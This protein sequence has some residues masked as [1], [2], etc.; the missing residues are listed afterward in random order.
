M[1]PDFCFG[2]PGRF[3]IAGKVGKVAAFG[4]LFLWEMD[5]GEMKILRINEILMIQM[6]LF[7]DYMYREQKRARPRD[8]VHQNPLSAQKF[9]A[10]PDLCPRA[11]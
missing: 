5:A 8:E 1:V 4:R 9:N 11:L 3:G 6:R 7:F 10:D 2:N